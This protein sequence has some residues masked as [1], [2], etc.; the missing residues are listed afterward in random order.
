MKKKIVEITWR[1]PT[2]EPGWTEDDHAKLLPYI[3]SYGIL[4]SK[5]TKQVVIGGSYGAS[6][7]K[8][9]DRTKFPAGCVE[10]IRVIE[11]VDLK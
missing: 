5:T 9:A 3:K 6:D 4:I 2:I 10:N 7:G 1:D 8:Y 11:T